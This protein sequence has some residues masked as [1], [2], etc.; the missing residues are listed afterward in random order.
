MC[1]EKKRKKDGVPC[2]ADLAAAVEKVISPGHIP[3]ARVAV[4][5]ADAVATAK[6]GAK[7]EAKR[8]ARALDDFAHL[9]GPIVYIH[10]HARFLF[11]S[12]LFFFSSFLLFFFSF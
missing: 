3:P 11:S 9:A 10:S 2:A 6:I 5:C 1:E 4:A 7:A 12:L 8:K